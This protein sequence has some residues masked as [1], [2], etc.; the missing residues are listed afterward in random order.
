MATVNL[1]T[2]VK[3]AMLIPLKDAIDA[4]G[5]FG[6]CKIYT[7][8]MPAQTTDAVTT[9][10]LLGTLTFPDPCGTISA[11]SL[12]MGSI[13]QDSSADATGIAA[14]ARIADS[15]GLVVKDINVSVTGGAGAMQMNTTNIV[16]NG[17]ILISSFVVSL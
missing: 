17:P 6:T 12:T 15:T 4:G 14:W 3:N 11:G 8:A 16:I 7:G 5:S 13:T 2:L 9:Q 10:V 1:A